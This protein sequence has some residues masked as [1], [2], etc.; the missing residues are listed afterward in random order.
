MNLLVVSP[1]V[2][3][4]KLWDATVKSGLG[5]TFLSALALLQLGG[6]WGELAVGWSLVSCGFIPLESHI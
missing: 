6:G 4:L 5:K 1:K 2:T 3:V